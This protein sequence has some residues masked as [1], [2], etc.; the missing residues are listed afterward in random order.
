MTIEGLSSAALIGHGIAYWALYQIRLASSK[1]VPANH[2]LEQGPGKGTYILFVWI[3][4]VSCVS[5]HARTVPG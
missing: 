4:D 3:V 2:G 1:Y 5:P